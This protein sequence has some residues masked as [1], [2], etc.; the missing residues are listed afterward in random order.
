MNWHK[1]DWRRIKRKRHPAH[2]VIRWFHWSWRPR[3]YIC[4]WEPRMS[5][6]RHKTLDL[7]ECDELLKNYE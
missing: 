7:K 1:Q 3:L 2:L 6:Q 5:E 4:Y